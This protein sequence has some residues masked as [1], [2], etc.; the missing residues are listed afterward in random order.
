VFRR[1]DGMLQTRLLRLGLTIDDL[2]RDILRLIGTFETL[3]RRRKALRLE[4][5][6]LL[7]RPSLIR[8]LFRKSARPRRGIP[9]GIAWDFK[10]LSLVDE[11]RWLNE[12]MD[13][14]LLEMKENMRKANEIQQAHGSLSEFVSTF[15]G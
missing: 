2:H 8:S 6:S 13:S 12:E 15:S 5:D 9:F 1:A 7:P 10:Y 4:L 14:T 3:D 11:S